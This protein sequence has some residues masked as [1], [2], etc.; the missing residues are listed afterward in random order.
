M[1]N[2]TKIISSGESRDASPPGAPPAAEPRAHGAPAGRGAELLSWSGRKAFLSRAG[3]FGDD[4]PWPHVL[5][6]SQA[7][8]KG[9]VNGKAGRWGS[10]GLGGPPACVPWGPPRGG[11]LGPASGVGGARGRGRADSATSPSEEREGPPRSATPQLRRG[12]RSLLVMGD[13]DRLLR[14]ATRPGP[15]PPPPRLGE[16]LVGTPSWPARA[17]TARG[18][19]RRALGRGDS[20]G[21]PGSGGGASAVKPADRGSREGAGV[22]TAALVTGTRFQWGDGTP[23]PT[24]QQS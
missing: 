20:T 18:R 24:D 16:T 8:L 11:L 1:L 4:R 14:W 12:L 15:R 21:V 5:S 3:G 19:R 9:A 6:G 13:P 7:R 10:S 17:V 23:R 2:K 22:R